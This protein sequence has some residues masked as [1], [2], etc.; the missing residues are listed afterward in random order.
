MVKKQCSEEVK[1]SLK[2]FSEKIREN[3]QNTNDKG[4]EQGDKRWVELF[5]SFDVVNSTKYKT[6]NYFGWSKILSELFHELQRKVAGEIQGAEIWRVLGDEVIF[7]K[8][9]KSIDEIY[10]S[11]S[12]VFKILTDSVF[13]LKSGEFFDNVSIAELDT[14]IELMKLQNI[15]SLQGSA[16]IAIIRDDSSEKIEP[17]DNI[18]EKYKASSEYEINEYL[19]NDIDA[20]FRVKE[21]TQDRRLAVSFEL[22]CILAE[23]TE[24]LSNLNIITYKKLKGIWNESLY[25]IIWF[26]DSRISNGIA[27]DDSFYYDEYEKSELAREYFDNRLNW[28]KDQRKQVMFSDVNKVLQKIQ[29][30]RGLIE[31]IVG[32]KEQISSS[33]SIREFKPSFLLQLHCVAVCCDMTNE[34]ILIAKRSKN[35]GVLS[36]KWEF[37]CA[38]AKKEEDISER[39]KLE[40]KQDFN[41]DIEVIVDSKRKDSQPI[42]LAI[43]EVPDKDGNGKHKGVITIAKIKGEYNPDIANVTEKHQQ[44]RWIKRDEVDTFEGEA[45]CDFKDTLS[46]VF[47]WLEQNK[48]K[49][50]GAET[51]E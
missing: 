44:V 11:V 41:I 37:G 47:D 27:F 25:P 32:I 33:D 15:I 26:H 45:V 3:K 51:K 49:S 22:A 35:R 10:E 14:D 42:P 17:Y 9:M 39:I 50:D 46:K 30:D 20:G 24:Y 48:E 19:G 7:V 31:K 16:W 21:Y 5:F 29:K 28:D 8:K 34:R 38:K 18:F 12:R 40:Y 23:R 1:N 13:T 43:Y 2:K 36:E 6:I 4:K